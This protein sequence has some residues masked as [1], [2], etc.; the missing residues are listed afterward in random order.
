MV[1]GVVVVDEAREHTARRRPRPVRPSSLSSCARSGVDRGDSARAFAGAKLG[2]RRQHQLGIDQDVALGHVA[3]RIGDKLD[4]PVSSGALHAGAVAHDPRDVMAQ[5]GAPVQLLERFGQRASGLLL[6]ERNDSFE[7]LV[8]TG[9]KI[10]EV[11][12]GSEHR[13]L[14][15]LEVLP[16]VREYRVDQVARRSTG[17]FGTSGS[18][19]D[20][21]TFTDHNME[22]TKSS[23]K[24]VPRFL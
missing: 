9:V 14:E 18:L 4:L 10:D 7:A 20:H 8:F 5:P 1:T 15:R 6:E 22:V 23:L 24:E 16:H 17:G 13:V 21:T 2:T 3:V 11:A 19:V 12:A